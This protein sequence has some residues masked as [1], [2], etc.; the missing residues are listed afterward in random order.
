M[1]HCHLTHVDRET[2]E[3]LTSLLSFDNYRHLQQSLNELTQQIPP[4]HITI[5]IPLEN[6]FPVYGFWRAHNLLT[7]GLLYL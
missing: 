2:G 5:D 3:V 1:A 7:Q 4:E 6:N